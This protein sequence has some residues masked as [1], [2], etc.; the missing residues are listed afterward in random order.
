MGG[1]TPVGY[2]VRRAQPGDVDAVIEVAR[3]AWEATYEHI[4]PRW[5][6]ERAIAEW[7]ARDGLLRAVQQPG[8]AFFV[9]ENDGG[10]LVGFAQASHRGQS[11]DVELWRI[12]VLPE[13]QRQGLGRRLLQACVE[14]LGSV[15]PVRRVYVQVETENEPAV[16]AYTAWGFRLVRQ[17]EERIFDYPCRMT[18]L[19]LEIDADSVDLARA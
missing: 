7:Y 4:L 13:H 19:C 3:A 17:Y 11:E 2:M 6:R 9:A 12:Y 14:A 8:G 18:E 10:R 15:R 16:R 5:F 1:Q